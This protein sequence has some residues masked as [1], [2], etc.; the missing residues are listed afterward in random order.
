MFCSTCGKEVIKNAKFCKYCGG[1]VA[2][3]VVT[4]V[5]ENLKAVQ[6]YQELEGGQSSVISELSNTN[7]KIALAAFKSKDLGFVFLLILFCGPFGLLYASI[8]GGLIMLLLSIPLFIFIVKAAVEGGILFG[9]ASYFILISLYWI[10]CI[11]WGLIAASI[12][13]S[14]LVRDITVG[15]NNSKNDSLTDPEPVKNSSNTYIIGS[16]YLVIGLFIFTYI[17]S[18]N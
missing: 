18:K 7:V 14:D 3:Y 5:V 15:N 10:I 13:N 11:L 8:T 16:I 4:E 12:Y 9:L 6:P 2:N 1:Q 17:A